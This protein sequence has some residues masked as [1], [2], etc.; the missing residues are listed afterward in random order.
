MIES[1]IYRKSH[2]YSHQ[3]I[4]KRRCFEKEGN[5]LIGVVALF[6]EN[7]ISVKIGKVPES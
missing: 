4:Y 2:F 7:V 6:P 3:N 5:G 1:E